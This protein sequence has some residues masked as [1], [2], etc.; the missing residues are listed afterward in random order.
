M[1]LTRVV[2][3]FIFWRGFANWCNKILVRK[4][5]HACFYKNALDIYKPPRE[6][7]CGNFIVLFKPPIHIGWGSCMALSCEA[8]GHCFGITLACYIIL[9][10]CTVIIL[11]VCARGKRS[12]TVTR[13]R[14]SEINPCLYLL[15]KPAFKSHGICW[16]MFN[17]GML[18]ICTNTKTRKGYETQPMEMWFLFYKLSWMIET[19]KSADSS[20]ASGSE[21]LAWKECVMEVDINEQ[22]VSGPLNL[23]F[24]KNG[25]AI[26]KHL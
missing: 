14:F 5:L 7:T 8:N 9:T 16:C 2:S 23:I 20:E 4:F 13:N 3:C 18:C 19:N 10:A 22:T 12:W 25:V 21:K 1:L 11:L 17:I 15:D 24:E 6:A 26:A